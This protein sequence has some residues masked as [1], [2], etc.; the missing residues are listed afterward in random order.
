MYKTLIYEKKDNI[1]IL[2]IN[3]PDKL[4]AISNELTSELSKLLDDI[5]KD[6]ELR[7]L[8]ITGKGDKAFVAGADIKELVDRDAR[9]GRKVSQERQEIF[10]H[11][12]N[13]QIPVIAAVN[14][15]ALGGGLELALACSIRIC[16]D[17]AQFGA[18]EV[19]LGII[20]GDGG[21]QRLPRLIGLGRAMELILTGD[22]ID[23]QEAFRIGLVNKVFP[24]EE[25]MEKAMELAQK[26]ASRPPLAVRYAKEAV[27]R[28][29]E[30]D[31][32]SG[33]ALESYLHALSC[34]TEDKKEGVSAFLEKR[35]GKFKGK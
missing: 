4:N 3:R 25:L 35:K 10:S 23:A 22:F 17:K 32:A 2:T 20:P 30:G 8:I 6:E 27:N 31:T 16:S 33:F 5:E 24:L 12:E 18:P 7:V 9:Q 14:G 28:S 34:T 15:Y 29:Q 13:L 21:T 26:I 11:I 1:G 19:K